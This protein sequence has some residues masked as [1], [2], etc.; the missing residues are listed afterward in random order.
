VAL[1]RKLR[2][3]GIKTT[4]L[5]VKFLFEELA[6]ARAS[7]S[8]LKFLKQL[9]KSRALVLGDFGLRNYTNEEAT[10]LVDLL[11]ERY[12]KG[13]TIV[14]PQIDPRGWGKRFD[15][16]VIGEAI[17]DRLI[18]PSDRLVVKGGSYRERLSGQRHTNRQRL[19]NKNLAV[20]ELA[21]YI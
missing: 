12:R 5:P 9:R 4:F 11:E 15:D 7:G 18:H 1:G 19:K 6:A 10:A 8:Y 3:A 20:Q 2:A 17:I 16:P 13:V 21:E 14:T